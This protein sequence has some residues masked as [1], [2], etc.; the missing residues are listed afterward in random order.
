MRKANRERGRSQTENNKIPDDKRFDNNTFTRR[1]S[2]EL[3]PFRAPLSLSIVISLGNRRWVKKVQLSLGN[4]IRHLCVPVCEGYRE[5][6]RWTSLSSVGWKAFERRDDDDDHLLFIRRWN[7]QR[8]SFIVSNVFTRR[9]SPSSSSSLI[10]A[11]NCHPLLLFHKTKLTDLFLKKLIANTKATSTKK[12]NEHNTLNLS[13]KKKEKIKYIRRMW[14]WWSRD[15]RRRAQMSELERE[16]LLD[17][18]PW[19]SKQMIK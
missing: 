7:I 13:E 16:I 3:S 12:S 10:D 11:L 9:W 15:R 8:S 17:D 5:Q 6:R 18:T 1:W 4:F 14:W 2:N 19:R